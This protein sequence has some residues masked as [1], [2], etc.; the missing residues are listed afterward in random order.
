MIKNAHPTNT[1]NDHGAPASPRFEFGNFGELARTGPAAMVR[2]VERF[3]ADQP[4]LCLGAAATAG[5]LLGWWVK[6]R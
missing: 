4:G 2:A 6:R 1:T 3:V 5:I